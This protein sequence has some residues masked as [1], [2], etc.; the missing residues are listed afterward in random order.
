MQ[1]MLKLPQT[2]GEPLGKP[3]CPYCGSIET[4]RYERVAK[5][6]KHPDVSSVPVVRRRCRHCARTFRHYGAG[7]NRGSQSAT[8]K[9][10]S[11]F[12][13]SI[14]FSYS[15]IASLLQ[16]HGMRLAKSTVWRSLEPVRAEIVRLHRESKKGRFSVKTVDRD[17]RRTIEREPIGT[18]VS[19]LLTGETLQIQFR[20][21]TDEKEL[22]AAFTSVVARIGGGSA[23][24]V[25]EAAGDST[26]D[27]A[28]VGRDTDVDR[29][30]RR[31]ERRCRELTREAEEMMKEADEGDREK[32]RELID[33][34]RSIRR[35]VQG[36]K[37]RGADELWEI[38]TKYTWANGPGKGEE[39]TLWYRMRLFA[40][41]LWDRSDL[42]TERQYSSKSG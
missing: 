30:R 18:L 25:E 11:A 14:G 17:R 4:R 15:Q 5:K 20:S 32:I 7:I 41:R 22:T 38:Y 13:Y 16:H 34:C 24:Q 29:L 33:D 1:I 19:R 26:T 23:T 10:L 28:D 21:G 36:W 37:E 12:L 3:Q 27:L 2:D 9:A 8:V 39:A 35:L 6:V 42:F 31:V 40:L